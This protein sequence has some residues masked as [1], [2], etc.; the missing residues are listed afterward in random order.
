MPSSSTKAPAR[1]RAPRADALASLAPADRPLFQSLRQWRAKPARQD[2]VPPYVIL[3]NRELV[4]ILTA[5]P[6]TKTALQ[7]IEGIGPGKV[8]RYGDAILAQLVVAL[9]KPQ[10]T[11]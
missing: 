4:A 11:S 10:A 5:R 1:E 7:H 2:G 6:Q 3:T 9:A 8:A